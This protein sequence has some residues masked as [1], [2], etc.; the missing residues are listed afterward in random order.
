MVF[1]IWQNKGVL[2]P[3]IIFKGMDIKYKCETEFLGLYLTEDIKW[4]VHIQ[5][6]SYKLNRSYV[7]LSLKCKTS[8]NILRSMYFANFHLHL[9]YGI[10]FCGDDGESKQI[11]K[12]HKK[13]MRLISNVGRD[14]SC[15]VLFKTLIILP[16]PCMFIMGTVCY[17]NMNTGRLEKNSVR[18]N[19]NTRHRSDLQ[20]QFCRTDI[21]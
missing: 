9:R 3:Q 10:L 1:H 12:L 7:M 19:Y 14:T 4:D 13:V 17:I 11:F 5:N 15:R 20:S 18:H 8:V 6:L 16:F 21:F 2:K